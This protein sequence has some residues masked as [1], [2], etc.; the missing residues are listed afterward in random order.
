MTYV[1]IEEEGKRRA[2]PVFAA[3]AH[4]DAPKCPLSNKVANSPTGEA[5]T[6]ER[7]RRTDIYRYTTWITPKVYTSQAL[8]S[9]TRYSILSIQCP[10]QDA[11]KVCNTNEIRVGRR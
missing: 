5:Q 4:D 10:G 6:V 11:K 8:S 1:R 2:V 9:R 3:S 7:I